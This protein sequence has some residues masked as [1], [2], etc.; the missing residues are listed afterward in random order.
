MPGP[1]PLLGL[2]AFVE[3]GETGSI[4]G[5]ARRLGVTAGAVS[6]QIK[7]LEA[8]LDILLFE[9]HNREI[10]L[11]EPGIHLLASIGDAFARIE[12]A[13]DAVQRS[14]TDRRARLTVSTTASFAATWLVPRLGRFNELRPRIEVQVLTSPELIPIGSGPDRADVAIRHGL[15]AWPGL[16]AVPLLQPHLIPVGSPHLLADGPPIRFP[17]DC[18]RYPLLHDSMAADWRLWFQ[19]VGANH[20]DPRLTRG[21]RFSDATLL[22]R[23][24]IS[25]QG[26][27]LLRDTYAADDLAGGRLAIALNAP[28]PAEFAY[29]VVTRPGHSALTE[30]FRNWLIKEAVAD[31]ESRIA[32]DATGRG[33]LAR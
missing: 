5:A 20:H 27:A 24:A 1:L 31:G 19:A 29:Y 10:R 26:L 9:R 28:W 30:D 3:A 4:K 21:T 13:V 18:L 25:G 12:D 11:T 15:G 16:E 2:R 32:R 8:R 22:L 33:S 14:R 7:L 23:A 17:P 6:Q